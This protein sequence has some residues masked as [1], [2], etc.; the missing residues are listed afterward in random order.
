MTPEQRWLKATGEYM[1]VEFSDLPMHLRLKAVEAVERG[2][3]PFVPKPVRRDDKTES[4]LMDWDRHD[5]RYQN[6]Y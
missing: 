5:E 3:T 1:P 6:A 2:D 4:S